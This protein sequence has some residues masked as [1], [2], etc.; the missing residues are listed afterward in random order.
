MPQE[1]GAVLLLKHRLKTFLIHGL[2]A[3]G[4]FWTLVESVGAFFSQIKPDGILQYS[5]LVLPSVV[6][7]VWRAWPISR[8]EL[9]VPNSDTVLCI[10][11]GDIWKKQ[12]CVAIQ[13]NEFF[14]SLLGNHV[15]PNSLHGQFIR[16]VLRSQSSDF[17]RYV[18]QAL[19]NVPSEHVPRTS[20]NTKR[21]KI[22]TTAAID[23]G[24]QR[25]LLF[26]FTKTDTTTLK[27]S[28]SVHE[29]WDALAGLWAAITIHGNG[30][31]VSMPLVGGGLSG[32]GLP[33]RNLLQLLMTSFSYYTKKQKITGRLTIVLPKALAKEIDLQELN[34]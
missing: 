14:D 22:G 8:V 21:Y 26:A 32:V 2:A 27:A 10:E 5:F 16:D 6:Y 28:A 29:L 19:S 1:N 20:G 13:V 15:S 30:D 4:L 7:G 31:P 3:Y 17:D 24:P 34:F 23:I 18:T 9:A 25:Y 12:G 11:F 33:A